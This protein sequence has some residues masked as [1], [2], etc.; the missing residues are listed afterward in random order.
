MLRFLDVSISN[1]KLVPRK[2]GDKP[3]N[4]GGPPEFQDGEE[5]K[6]ANKKQMICGR[7]FVELWSSDPEGFPMPAGCYY[8]KK[9]KDNEERNIVQNFFREFFL[10]FPAGS[11]LRQNTDYQIVMNTQ[12]QNIAKGD[13]LVDLYTMCVGTVGC[14]RP[15]QVFEKGSAEA[16]KSTE[17]PATLSD[18]SFGTDGFLLQRGKPTD[19]VLNLSEMNILQFKLTGGEDNAAII[20]NCL[21]RVYL[22]PLTLWAVGE[23]SCS[24]ECRKYHANNRKCEGPVGCTPEEVVPGSE[25]RNVIKIQLPTEMHQ[26]TGTTTHTIK[27]TGL[28]LPVGGYFPSRVGAQVTRPD[29]SRPD[30]KTST[31]F[32]MKNAEVGETTGRLVVAGRTG[33]GPKPFRADVNNILFLRLS[34]GA[35]VWNLGQNNAAFVEITLPKG[36]TCKVPDDGMPDWTLDTFTADSNNDGYYDS[37]R[38]YM[39]TATSDGDWENSAGKKCIYEVR[40]YMAIFAGM[41]VYVKVTVDNPGEPMRKTDDI[42]FWSIRLQSKGMQD[43]APAAF[44]QPEEKFITLAQEKALGA[45]HWGG[46]AAVLSPLLYETLQPTN[47]QRSTAS[48]QQ[49]EDLHV[50][51]RTSQYI[52]RNG[53]VLLDSPVGFDFGANCMAGE[54]PGEYYVFRGTKEDKLLPLKNIKT[55]AGQSFPTT[56]TTYNRAKIEVGGI[57]DREKHYGFKIRITHPLFYETTQHI[58]WYLWTQDADGFGVDGSTAT[59]KFNR[60]QASSQVQPWHKAWG[61]YNGPFL[62]DFHVEIADM[63]PKS[64]SSSDSIVTVWPFTFAIFTDTSLRITAPLGYVWDANADSFTGKMNMSTADITDAPLFE[65][66]NQLVWNSISFANNQVYGFQ[67]KIKVP[68]FS[69]VV[70][71]NA[72]FVE[73]GWNK[74]IIDERMMAAVIPAKAVKTLT[75]CAVSYASNLEAYT[76]NRMEFRFK[77]VTPLYENEG[78]VIKG[79]VN[80]MGFTFSCPPILLAGSATL[81]SDL[82]C[83]T[84]KGNDDLPKVRLKVAQTP[85]LPGNYAFEMASI[86]PSRRILVPGNWQFG[87]YQN[88][89]EFPDCP[90]IDRSLTSPGFTINGPILD[91]RLIS[92]TKE[93][94]SLTLRNDR[95]DKPNQLIFRFEVRNTPPN[96]ADLK[97]RGPRG[98]EFEEDCL[99]SVKTSAN[100]VFGPNTASTWPPDYAQWPAQFAPTACVGEGRFA[101][102]TIPAGLGRRNLYAFRIGVLK[103]PT[104][105]P[106]WN[107]WTIDYISESSEPFE[108]FTVWTFTHTSVT[109]VSLAKSPTGANVA[110]TINPITITFRP[111]NKVPF[112]CTACQFGGLLRLSAPTGFEFVENNGDCHEPQL[113]ETGGTMEFTPAD[114]SCQVEHKTKLLLEL[115]GDKSVEAGRDYTLIVNAY[116]PTSTA[117]ADYW[118]LHSFMEKSAMPHQALD[119]HTTILGQDINNVLNTWTVINKNNLRNGKAKVNDVEFT[120]QFP[121]PLKDG[122]EIIIKGPKGFDLEGNPELGD[123]KEFR[124]P[125]NTVPLPESPPGCTCAN[126]V[127][128]MRFRIKENKDP[129]YPQNENIQFTVATENPTRTPFVTENFWRVSHQRN[130]VVRSSHIY[131]SW[132]INPQLEDVTINLV[133]GAQNQAAGTTS[134]LIF[135]FTAV[136]DADTIQIEALFPTEFDFGRATVPVP[137]DIDD[138]SEREMIII[139]RCSIVAGRSQTIRINSV[140]LGRGGGQT[141]FNMITYSDET[142]QHKRDEKLEYTGGFRLPG[143]VTVDGKE[144]KS[145]FKE[146][147]QLFPVKS[148]FQARV[149]EEAKAE[150]VL[151]FSQKVAAAQKLVISCQGEGAY[152]LKTSPF[153]I[154]GKERVETSV[155]R[156]ANKFTEI[157]ATLKPGRPAT[158]VA[159]QADTPYTIIMW[160]IPKQGTNTWL[161]KTSDGGQYPTNTND[162]VTTGFRPVEQMSLQIQAIRSPPRAIIDVTL[163]VDQRSA[164]VLELLVIAPPSFV[165]PPTGCGDMCQAGQALGSTGRRTA[166]IASP[167]GEPLTRLNNLRIQ[168]QT[169]EQTPDSITWFVEG[170]G[171]GKGV[172]TGWGEGGGFRVTQMANSLVSYAGVAGLRAAQITFRFVLEVNAGSEIAIEPPSGYLLSCS[173]EGALKQISLPGGRPGC[174]DD[175]LVLMLSTTLTAG[176]YAFGVAVDLPPQKPSP[177]SFNIIIRDRDNNVVDAAYELGGVDIIP[178]PVTSPTLSWTRAEP[179]QPSRIT[180]GITFTMDTNLIKALLIKFPNKFIHDVQKPTDVQNLNRRFPVA[181]SQAGGW[182]DTSDTDRIKILLDDS[183]DSTTI[184]A[185]TYSWS[186]PVLVPS[187]EMPRYNVWFFSLCSDRTCR[188]PRGRGVIVSFPMAGFQLNEVSPTAARSETAGARPSLG[189]SLYIAIGLAVSNVLS[190]LLLQMIA[191]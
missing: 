48:Y 62:N 88:V 11:G 63:T 6:P 32:L 71:S 18:P 143:K 176:E 129:A 2:T 87:T 115:I 128:T 46:N 158:D 66:E 15:Y 85:M 41:I 172:T 67:A 132:S 20:A 52:G 157:M 189:V 3:P 102:L 38:G 161:F 26:I 109:P 24:A 114:M 159:L 163:N 188:D 57:L 131:P 125:A 118:A 16:S 122:D 70:S 183:E 95:P 17:S 166:T 47:F 173:T 79:D 56:A 5:I 35:T 110:L 153:V 174:T 162:G 19:G 181:A 30:Y 89:K 39:S 59:I 148:L 61:M 178:L 190:G 91:S 124:W 31:G 182:A 164:V 73:M 55:C 99:Q 42:N 53:F 8:G 180:I 107:K 96:T 25:R 185:D 58:T 130:G 65:N 134:D 21:V 54:L 160:V 168:V 175:P 51:F 184:A 98:F 151:M 78:V 77:S 141:K 104:S 9:Y 140:K 191:H 83:D 69:P 93:Q 108:G 171:Q 150:F 100:E 60:N 156:A 133:E 137:Y 123:C 13:V 97:L 34:F 37:V 165:F 27:V 22:W 75:D 149:G 36:Y 169:P 126:L 105:T 4:T 152:E 81:P 103:N 154:I 136:S 139:N 10:E 72:F 167:T 145:K 111:F 146:E 119:E 84:D 14:E 121:D 23:G 29:D 12:V 127:C 86:N 1:G 68:D 74:G 106:E 155:E 92:L 33:Y 179:A 40:P 76:S 28:T 64:I 135:T 120:L 50:Y 90:P 147:R 44:D 113:M 187:T 170:R 112:K 116:N 45:T 49:T 117:L 144:L 7:L 138:L 177:N 186:F 43:L 82:K 80:T 142:R 94:R 101:T